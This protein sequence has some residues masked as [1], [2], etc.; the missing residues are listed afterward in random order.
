M[1]NYGV[2]NVITHY[3]L[4]DMQYCTRRRGGWVRGSTLFIWTR[5]AERPAWAWSIACSNSAGM[6][7]Q[8]LSSSFSKLFLIGLIN[9]TSQH[10]YHSQ[11]PHKLYNL[12]ETEPTK[13]ST[14][15]CYD[16]V[17]RRANHSPYVYT[18]NNIHKR[19]PR[20][21]EA[22][23]YHVLNIT[24]RQTFPYRWHTGLISSELLVTTFS[25]AC[26]LIKSACCMQPF[27]YYHADWDLARIW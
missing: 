11:D 21:L 6:W 26:S 5:T 7:S 4:V 22:D 8:R 3:T 25:F 10:Q 18:D 17:L 1:F 14:T 15:N 12:K 13:I 20:S 23:K 27:Q 2:I 16:V 19:D 9:C 24:Y